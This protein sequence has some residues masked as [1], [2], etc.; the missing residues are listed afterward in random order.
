[1]NE[2]ANAQI[3][4]LFELCAGM[5]IVEAMRVSGHGRNASVDEV[6]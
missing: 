1:M 5:G 3:C 4:D 6:K 2:R